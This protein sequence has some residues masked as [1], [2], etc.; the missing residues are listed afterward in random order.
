VALAL[1]KSRRINARLKVSALLRITKLSLSIT[2][3]SLI[4]TCEKGVV[5]R[6]QYLFRLDRTL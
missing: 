4:E 3:F 2:Y 5:S 1:F 6:H